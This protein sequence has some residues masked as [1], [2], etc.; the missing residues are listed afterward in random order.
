MKGDARKALND[1]VYGLKGIFNQYDRGT[2]VK[3]WKAVNSV[4][5]KKIVDGLLNSPTKPIVGLP[6]LL[7]FKEWFETTT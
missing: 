2:R 1:I 3:A 7:H 4:E 5:G 6:R